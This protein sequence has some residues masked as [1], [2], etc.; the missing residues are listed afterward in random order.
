MPTAYSSWKGVLQTKLDFSKNLTFSPV[1]LVSVLHILHGRSTTEKN[2]TQKLRSDTK[3][4]VLPAN[5]QYI[6][7]VLIFEH[8]LFNVRINTIDAIQISSNIRTPEPCSLLMLETVPNMKIEYILMRFSLPSEFQLRSPPAPVQIIEEKISPDLRNELLLDPP[9]LLPSVNLLSD[10][11]R[12]LEVSHILEL[13][14]E[15]S[16]R[17]NSVKDLND[18]RKRYL[19]DSEALIDHDFA[20][21]WSQLQSEVHQI[22]A[23]EEALR[24]QEEERLKRLNAEKERKE[25]EEAEKRA[26]KEAEAKKVAEEQAKLKAIEDA[27]RKKE[28]EKKAEEERA[29][30][31]EEKA[32]AERNKLK[33]REKIKKEQESA[34]RKPKG[35]TD[36]SEIEKQLVEHR[37][38]IDSIKEEVVKPMNEAKDLKKHASVLKRKI[39]IKLGQLSNS[40][41]QLNQISRDVVNIANETASNQLAYN[42]ILNFIS[43]AIVSQA[44]TEVTV[45]PTAALPLAR[46]SMHLLH[47]LPGLYDFLCPRFVK[48]CCFIIGF[49]CPIDTEE[50][51]I[52]MGWRRND[53]KWEPEVKYEERVGGICSV[54]AVMARLEQSSDF[55]FFSAD[56]EWKFVARMLNIDKSLLSNAHFVIA[57]N[58][59]EAAALLAVNIWGKQGLK[60]L[61]LLSRGWAKLGQEKSFPAATR[62]E[63]LGDDYESKNNLNQLKEMEA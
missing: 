17:L 31:A 5:F 1:S 39:N 19:K 16:T 21:F 59:W 45:K 41:S 7:G 4:R 20:Q 35:L 48:K 46:L 15:W 13:N 60:L 52:R 32:N 25:K 50:G 26:K 49:T 12:K 9:S 27:A 44:E 3:Q 23:H 24:K 10:T 8:S 36:F 37:K 43:K 33:L 54:W 42:W 61:L 22:I 11:F 57:S 56:A 47:N 38:K 6:C 58:W 55:P 53:S 28:D 51:R 14:N 18:E 63:V 34:A 40:M 2:T 29:K 62:L 30:A